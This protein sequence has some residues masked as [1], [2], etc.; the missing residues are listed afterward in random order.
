MSID[1]VVE[2]LNTFAAEN[3]IPEGARS[4]LQ[5]MVDNNV[6]AEGAELFCHEH[7]MSS[8]IAELYKDFFN[9]VLLQ[10]T[11]TKSTK[12]TEVTKPEEP[13]DNSGELQTIINLWQE[14]N[15]ILNDI[16]TTLKS[17]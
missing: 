3:N 10:Q 1:K 11:L 2:M 5:T 16:A 13:S 6:S 7:Y 9:Y 17:V 15:K 14:T 4:L 12:K 8:G